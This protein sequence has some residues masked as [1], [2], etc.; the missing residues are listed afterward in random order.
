MPEQTLVVEL[1]FSMDEV[2]TI[3]TG[4]NKFQ[5]KNNPI[6]PEEVM[7]NPKLKAFLIEELQLCTDEVVAGSYEATANDWL[8]NIKDYRK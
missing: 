2:K 1:Q 6:T 4:I 3:L 5:F 7:G 8:F